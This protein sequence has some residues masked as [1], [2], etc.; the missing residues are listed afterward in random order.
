[1]GM[2]KENVIKVI[3]KPSNIKSVGEYGEVFE[4][5]DTNY[6]V[7]INQQN[8]LSSIKIKELYSD[9]YPVPK[10][11]KILSFKNISEIF[12][13]NNKKISEIL[14]PGLEIYK[15]DKVI[16]FKHSWRNE[17]E[18]DLSGIYSLIRESVVGLDK[19]DRTNLDEYEENMR[20]VLNQN[21]K[22]VLKFKKTS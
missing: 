3:G 20:V 10:S 8:K 17:I 1:M 5:D 22:H 21:I 2:T 15:E 16:F 6:S 19:V 9:Y 14:S 13:S 12:K 18:N 7:E 4:Y 11:E